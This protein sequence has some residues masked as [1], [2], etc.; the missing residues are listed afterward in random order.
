MRIDTCWRHSVV[1]LILVAIACGGSGNSDDGD[2]GSGDDGSVFAIMTIRS[3]IE[4]GLLIVDVSDAAAPKEVGF[5]EIDVASGVA[6]VGDLAYATSQSG[7]SVIDI[8]DLKNPE[9][10][11][12]VETPG[13]GKRPA[14]VGNLAF[15]PDGPSGLQVIDVT[16]STEPALI[17]SVDDAPGN[18]I[19]VT[20][21]GDYAY[22]GDGFIEGLR[23][24]DISNP[25]APVQVS[26]YTTSV[27]VLGV[28][29]VDDLAYMSNCISGLLVMDVSN[30]ALPVRLGQVAVRPEACVYDVAVNG[31]YA[32]IAAGSIGGSMRVIDV[33]N[34]AGP[35]ETGFV[36]TPKSAIGLAVLGDYVYVGTSF[37]GLRIFDVADP[38]APSEVSALDDRSASYSRP[39]IVER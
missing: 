19:S 34:S 9:L 17:G 12:F 23:V 2:G 36:E 1:L 35:I 30:S 21:A 13:L 8:S 25:V 32:Y 15:V 20:V 14:V 22:V 16:V 3:G 28:V 37:A 33:S 4:S 7:L 6:V 26:F 10:L 24:I 5:L 18:Y 31:Q 38:A 29:I 27:S 11:G 39:V